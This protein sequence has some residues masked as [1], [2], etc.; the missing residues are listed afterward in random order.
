MGAEK[1]WNRRMELRRHLR[2]Y[3]YLIS[4]EWTEQRA[5]PDGGRMMKGLM[6][7]N[8]TNFIA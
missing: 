2:G 7:K 4:L 5:T 3:A 1:T 8:G 6:G